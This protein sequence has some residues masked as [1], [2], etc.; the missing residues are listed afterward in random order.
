MIF[1]RQ[2]DA[3]RQPV[4]CIITIDG[5]EIQALYPYLKEVT[6]EMNREA[7]T[8]ATLKFD[9]FRDETGA[10][11]VQDT[12]GSDPL[13]IPWRKVIIEA[14]FGSYKEEVMRG[15]ISKVNPNYPEDMSAAMVTVMIQDESILLDR[16]HIRRS[17]VTTEENS[18][19]D[20]D[21]VR[22][23]AGDHQ[24]DSEVQDGFDNVSLT[25][26]NTYVQFLRDRAAAN[27]YEFY[28]RKGAI[29]F[30]PPELGGRAS[31]RYHGVCRLGHQ[32]SQI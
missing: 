20:G 13:F 25:N 4:E 19:S 2:N 14:V 9:T 8:V 10:W 17:W 22:E 29:H 32:L 1:D 27:G 7:A 31:T 23:I 5:E 26:N 12:G 16:E 15:Y 28:I 24:L 18:I 3:L 11:L 21:I 6:V 30:H